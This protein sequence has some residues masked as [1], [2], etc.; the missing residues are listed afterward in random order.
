MIVRIRAREDESESGT[1]PQRRNKNNVHSS[2]AKRSD[3][4]IALVAPAALDST[5]SALSHDPHNVPSP[6]HTPSA[7]L[8]YSPAHSRSPT[9]VSDFVS[10]SI[11]A[12][13]SGRWRR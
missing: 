6:E 12:C 9:P 8:D 5:S 1:K 7:A 3:T 11:D 13:N 4:D 2:A 10:Q